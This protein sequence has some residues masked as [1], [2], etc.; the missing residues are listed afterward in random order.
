M[1]RRSLEG[2]ITKRIARFRGPVG[3]VLAVAALTAAL[4]CGG[5]NPASPA[6][7][8]SQQS[9]AGYSVSGVVTDDGG[10]PV[11]NAVVIL[12]HGPRLPDLNPE[13]LRLT[14][15]TSAVGRYQFNIAP[16]QL[17]A[18]V[19]PFAMIRAYTNVQTHSGN[20]Q[21][22]A[23]EGTSSIK[24]IRLSRVRLIGA[25]QSIAVLIDANSSL[26]DFGEIGLATR[27]EWVRIK[28]PTDGTLT[29]DARSDGGNVPTVRT[30]HHSEQGTVSIPVTTEDFDQV[31]VAIEV[32]VGTTPQGFTVSTTLR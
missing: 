19:E 26:C 9:T 1:A 3:I 29:I 25:G 28:Y 32:P 11:P 18:E 10:A 17:R 4:A 2:N 7:S 15:R 12:D 24:N 16:G 13:T 8:G 6:A 5:N 20:I 31:S 23:R 21:L 22:L 30:W 27:C 14:T